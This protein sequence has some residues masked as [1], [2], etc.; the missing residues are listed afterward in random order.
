M[1]EILEYLPYHICNKSLFNPLLHRL[2]LDH[3]IIFYFWTTLEKLK[4]KFSK[5]LNT[6]QNI[7]E[8]GAFAQK[9]QMLHFPEY[10]Q[11]HDTSKVSKGNIM[12]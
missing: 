4:K 2:N 7:M 10:F 8:N 11:I 12:E 1:F 5:V 9:E 3:D 6:F